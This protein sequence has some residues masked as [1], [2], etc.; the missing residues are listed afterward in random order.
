MNTSNAHWHSAQQHSYLV[1]EIGSNQ[2]L[3]GSHPAVFVLNN[4]HT[5]SLTQHRFTLLLLLLCYMFQHVLRH[6]SGMSIQKPYKER[7]NK[8]TKNLSGR[9]FIILLYLALYGFCIDIPEECLS[10]GRNMQHKCKV[11]QL[12]VCCVKLNKRDLFKT[13]HLFMVNNSKNNN[14]NNKLDT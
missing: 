11:N 8:N 2:A 7:Y 4:P 5:F 6:S 3:Y 10:T 12:N 14:I 9:R 1:L 13:G